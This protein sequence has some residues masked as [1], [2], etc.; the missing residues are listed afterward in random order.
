MGNRQWC[1]LVVLP[2]SHNFSIAPTLFFSGSFPVPNY[3]IY[4]QPSQVYFPSKLRHQATP[5]EDELALLEQDEDIV[6]VK[7]IFEAFNGAIEKTKDNL[8]IIVL[9]HAPST[10]VKSIPKGHLVEE[11]R[12]G[13]KLIPLDWL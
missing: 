6:Q 4:D 13:I 1:E 11:W 3:I 12:N 10:L 7:K 9:D 8:Q 2:C 5:E